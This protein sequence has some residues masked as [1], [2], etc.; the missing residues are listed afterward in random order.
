LRMESPN[1]DVHLRN[2]PSRSQIFREQCDTG[3]SA[4]RADSVSR[5]EY[6][7]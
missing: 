5:T 1:A 7:G 2:L 4:A 3:A 6:G